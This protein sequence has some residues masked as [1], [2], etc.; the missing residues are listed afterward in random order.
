MIHGLFDACQCIFSKIYIQKK[1]RPHYQI[2]NALF[3]DFYA[4]V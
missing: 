3:I 2:G 4:I 1:E